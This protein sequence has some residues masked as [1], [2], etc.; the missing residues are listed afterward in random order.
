[1]RTPTP[2]QALTIAAARLQG[3]GGQEWVDFVLALKAYRQDALEAM[4]RAPNAD[5]HLV[6]MAKGRAAALTELNQHLA[7]PRP[8]AE[9]ILAILEKN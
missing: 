5:A 1:M 8:A 2:E 7:E 6:Y 3:V 9:K 4:L